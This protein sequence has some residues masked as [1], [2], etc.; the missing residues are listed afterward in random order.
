MNL[1]QRNTFKRTPMRNTKDMSDLPTREQCLSTNPVK[2]TSRSSMKWR[3]M[4][5]LSFIVVIT[6]VWYVHGWLV[7]RKNVVRPAVTVTADIEIQDQFNITILTPDLQARKT[8]KLI[9]GNGLKVYIVSDPGIVKAGAALSVETGAWR[10]PP[11]VSGLGTCS[12]VL[13]NCSAFH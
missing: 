8:S 1:T 5:L 13:F 11:G 3:I 12:I 10:D 6:G 7:P 2:N 9:L 4:R